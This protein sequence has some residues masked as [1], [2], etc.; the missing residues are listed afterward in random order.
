MNVE[1]HPKTREPTLAWNKEISKRQSVIKVH[2]KPPQGEIPK[3]KVR[4]VC[5]SDTHSLTHRIQFDICDGDIFIHA[6]DFTNTGKREEVIEF[7]LWLGSLPHKHKLV[8]AGNHELSFDPSHNKPLVLSK[9]DCPTSDNDR[10]FRE[11]LTNCT[12]LEDQLVELYGLKIYGTPWQP[13]FGNWA[14]NVPRGQDILDKW[15]KI[16]ADIDI[17]ISHGPP[18]GH[19]DL[20]RSGLR[21]G[22]VELLSTLQQRVKPKFHIFGHIHEGYGVTSDGKITFINAT[23]CNYQYQPVNHPIVFDMDLPGDFSKDD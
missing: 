17:L 23:T 19:G 7:N 10:D 21:A 18:I 1:V 4:I 20:C 2:M 5:M 6:G 16:P 13:E 3:N 15:N 14:F 9:D 11:Y 12:Y 22:C 8:I